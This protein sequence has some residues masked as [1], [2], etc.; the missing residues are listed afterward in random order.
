MSSGYLFALSGRAFDALHFHAFRELVLMFFHPDARSVEDNSFRFQSQSLFEP[1]FTGKGD[2]SL[3]PYDTMPGKTACRAQCPNYLACAAWKARRQRDISVG[4]DLALG[5]F[6]NGLADD[7]EHG[8][9]PVPIP[10]QGP[11]QALFERIL[12]IVA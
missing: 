7:F 2:F 4:G 1:V 8:V 6:S 3:G 10:C 11:P 9:L 5:N 12:R